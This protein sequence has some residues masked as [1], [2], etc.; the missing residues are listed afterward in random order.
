MQSQGEFDFE[1]TQQLYEL[2]CAMEEFYDDVWNKY[3]ESTDDVESQKLLQICT[4]INDFEEK[5]M[6]WD[7]GVIE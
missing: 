6:D 3:I 5:M 1:A 2:K 4:D 7:T